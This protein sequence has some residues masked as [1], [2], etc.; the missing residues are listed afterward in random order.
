MEQRYTARIGAMWKK[1]G[2]EEGREERREGGKEGAPN[3]Q[4]TLTLVFS[5]FLSLSSR[6]QKPVSFSSFFRRIW[7]LRGKTFQTE[8]SFLTLRKNSRWHS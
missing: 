4:R 8:P 3:K 7:M 1:G 6:S 2:R 5:S